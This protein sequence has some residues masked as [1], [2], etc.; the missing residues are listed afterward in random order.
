MSET[1]SP[2]LHFLDQLLGDLEADLSR[3]Q[4]AKAAGV[5]LG[6]M[7]GLPELDKALGGCLLPGVHVLHAAP[8]AGKTALGLQIAGDC[9]FPAIFTSCEM[10]SLELLR[11]VVARGSGCFLDRFKSGELTAAEGAAFARSAV[12]ACPKL[13]LLDLTQQT[14][15]W[16]Y[17]RDRALAARERF[18]AVHVLIVLD[19]LHSWTE[20]QY[21]G[22][23]YEGVNAAMAD[24]RK[25]AAAL[26]CAVLAISERNRESMGKG[27]QHAGAGSRK[28]EYSAETVIDLSRE[29]DAVRD[30]WGEVPVLA[31]LAKNR[32]GAAG[33]KIPLKFHGAQQKF[34]EG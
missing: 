5:L 1:P 7:T 20:G 15:G 12:A 32:H 17:L 11:R 16:E 27:G 31:R 13:A 33:V 8:G 18:D 26:N 6:P 4:A 21:V 14:A 10:S 9:G 24:L 29:A 28:I 2:P 25:L 3:R 34:R 23:E 19:S 30:A 22:D